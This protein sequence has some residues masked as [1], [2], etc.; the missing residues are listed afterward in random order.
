MKQGGGC[1]LY[2]AA[3]GRSHLLSY[4]R[5]RALHASSNSSWVPHSAISRVVDVH[6]FYLQALDGDRCAT[7]KVDPPGMRFTHLL[8][9]RSVLVSTLLVANP[10]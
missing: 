10:G 7:M 6:D 9:L 8:Q 2:S 3:G 1:C 4:Q 5:H